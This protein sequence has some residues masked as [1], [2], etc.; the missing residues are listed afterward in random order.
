MNAWW[1]VYTAVEYCVT[2]SGAAVAD[3]D[4]YS[5]NFV[6]N[7]MATMRDKLYFTTEKDNNISTLQTIF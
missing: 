2:V 7:F 3:S 6:N 1:I 4:E 5:R